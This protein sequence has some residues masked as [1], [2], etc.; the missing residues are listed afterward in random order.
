MSKK[1]ANYGNKN[2]LSANR[3]SLFNC[4]LGIRKKLSKLKYKIRL[5]C[6][7]INA[8]HCN[9]IVAPALQTFKN[10]VLKFKIYLNVFGK[11]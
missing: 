2:K 7:I 10:A 5:N 3:F 1:L 6:I 8:D 9:Y 11:N 4:K